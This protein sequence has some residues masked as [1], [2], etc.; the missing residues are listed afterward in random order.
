MHLIGSLDVP[1]GTDSQHIPHR[2]PW[3]QYSGFPACFTEPESWL[4]C[5]W[6][7]SDTQHCVNLRYKTRWSPAFV[8]YNMAA[9][10][11]TAPLLGHRITFSFSSLG[12]L[13]FSPLASLTIETQYCCDSH[14]TECYSWT[15]LLVENAEKS[16]LID[17]S[18]HC[19]L[20]ALFACMPKR[21]FSSFL[22]SSNFTG[23]RFGVRYSASTFLGPWC[24]LSVASF[25]NTIF[26]NLLRT[27]VL[28]ICSWFSSSGRRSTP[29]LYFGRSL[30]TCYTYRLLTN[31]FN[32][33]FSVLY[34]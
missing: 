23:I 25:K 8:Y 12:S 2:G 14:C 10:V 27:V 7:I 34:F 17:F 11:A 28:S 5:Y 9:E 15:V 22:W 20:S 29:H 24:A 16:E 4:F 19:K 33:F 1:Q 13:R 31:H 3:G 26:L 18:F 6:N 21:F 30:P 32:L